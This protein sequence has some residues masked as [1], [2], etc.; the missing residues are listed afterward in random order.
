VTGGPTGGFRGVVPPGQHS[1]SVVICVFTMRRWDDMLA[2]I[3]SVRAQSQ[4]AHELIV[5][6]DHNA[7]LL[8]RLR[9]QLAHEP[10]SGSADQLP[11]KV[12]ANEQPR[13]LSGGK[14][15]GVAHATGDIVAFLDDDAI[16][17]SKW[18][19]YLTDSYG[20]PEVTGVGG[21][22]LPNWDTARPAWFPR[23]FDWV[24]GC[25]YL[26][27]PASRQPV[28]NLLGGNASFRRPVFDQVGGFSV[29]VGRS[30][31]KLPLGGEETE[32]CIKLHQAFSERRGA[33]WTDDAGAPA[34][35]EEGR[36][37]LRRRSPRGVPGG[38]PPGL[39]LRG[40]PG[41][42]P[43]GLAPRGV[44]GGRPPG[45][46]PRVPGGRPAGPMLLIDDR[47]VI[48]HRV[49]AERTTLRY[50]LTR[51]YAEGVSK[52]AVSGHV[53]SADGLSAERKQAFATLPAGIARN[54][55]A[56]VRGDGSGIGRAAAIVAGLAAATAGYAMGRLTRR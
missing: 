24:V 15:T 52:A 45:L 5:V 12:V 29:N 2:A 22:T 35:E 46:A 25:N 41:G 17:D 51:C 28:R 9:A 23:E 7:E 55:A 16:A 20:A 49:G 10:A 42:R 50:F 56:L 54:L 34:T 43:P 1:V 40:V 13:G 33:A 53:G 44:P 39:A 27:M 18:L 8:G 38:R 11:V 4:P 6:V 14:N 37:H 19:K 48:W 36:R 32:F 3:G 47:A 21:L 26:G 31:S 30:A